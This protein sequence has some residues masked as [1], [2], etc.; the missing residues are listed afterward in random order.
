[1][2]GVAFVGQNQARCYERNK[3]FY[4]RENFQDFAP[5]G[6]GSVHKN[7]RVCFLVLRVLPE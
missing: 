6:A 2:P 4:P 5:A 3:R 7:Y 1:M